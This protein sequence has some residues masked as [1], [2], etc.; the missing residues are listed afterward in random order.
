MGLG[1]NVLGLGFRGLG[2][3][4]LGFSDLALQ[5]TSKNP[6]KCL[7]L[8]S[9]RLIRMLDQLDLGNAASHPR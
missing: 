3:R 6:E 7:A 8:G 4:G 1:F 2:F 5:G 9:I